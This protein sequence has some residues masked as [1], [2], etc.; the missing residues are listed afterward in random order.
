MSEY[1]VCALVDL[2]YPSQDKGAEGYPAIEGCTTEYVGWMYVSNYVLVEMYDIL[3]EE[4]NEEPF[5]LGNY[6][7]PPS[8]WLSS[9]WPASSIQA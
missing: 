8:V 1:I 6:D 2:D 4:D 3:Y 5:G 9:P 7:W